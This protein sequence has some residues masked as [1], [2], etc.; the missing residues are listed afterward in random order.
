MTTPAPRSL[1]P[2]DKVEAALRSTRGFHLDERGHVRCRW[3]FPDFARAF[4]FVTEIA[5]LA[6]QQNHHPDLTCGWGH[7]ELDL[8]THDRGGITQKDLDLVAA[9][10]ALDQKAEPRPA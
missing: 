7:V 4:A 10:E 2:K 9:I 3:R 6:E 8:Y 5:K 1:L